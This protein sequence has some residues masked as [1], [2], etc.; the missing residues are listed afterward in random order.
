[1]K[2]RPMHDV[3]QGL[4]RRIREVGSNRRSVLSSWK[5]LLPTAVVLIAFM[6]LPWRRSVHTPAATLTTRKLVS[7]I[8][9]GRVAAINIEPGFGVQGSWKTSALR[10]VDFVVLYTAADIQPLLN[11]AERSAVAVSFVPVGTSQAYRGW[12]SLGIGLVIVASLFA[13]SLFHVP[14]SIRRLECWY[15]CAR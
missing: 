10:G 7:A 12:I 14:Q 5:F 11:H 2:D 9:G 6:L 3:E 15:Y 8:D 13:G 1:M 4:P